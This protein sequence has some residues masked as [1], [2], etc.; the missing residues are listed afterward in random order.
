MKSGAGVLFPGSARTVKAGLGAE[1]LIDHP[2]VRESGAQSDLWGTRILLSDLPAIVLLSSTK[3]ELKE[4][5]PL[6]LAYERS[7]AWL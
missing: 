3:G 7:K 2:F 5:S 4:R 1:I 6:H